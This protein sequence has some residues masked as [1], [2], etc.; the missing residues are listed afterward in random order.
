MFED[1]VKG[2]E[3]EIK[4]EFLNHKIIVIEEVELEYIDKLGAYYRAM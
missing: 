4:R 2:L 3:D 1:K